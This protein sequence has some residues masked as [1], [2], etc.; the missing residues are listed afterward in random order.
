MQFV[1]NVTPINNIGSKCHTK[2]LKSSS[3]SHFMVYRIMY[4]NRSD[5]PIN[6]KAMYSLN[7][8][9]NFW[10]C[11]FYIMYVKHICPTK[12]ELV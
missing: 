4:V 7:Y 8:I 2:K 10:V 6:I 12:P 3:Y 11:M 5:L 9:S 1:I